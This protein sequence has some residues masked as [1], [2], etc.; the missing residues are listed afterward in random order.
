MQTFIELPRPMS[1]IGKT[2]QTSIDARKAALIDF[3]QRMENLRRCVYWLVENGV[4]VIS[5]TMCRGG[6]IVKVSDSPRLHMVIGQD[7]AWRKRRQE[8]A[9]TIFTMFA[10]RFDTRVEWDQVSPCA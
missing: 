2:P 10:I 9:L 8:G 5:S 6:G 7:Y 3:D 1:A 4:L